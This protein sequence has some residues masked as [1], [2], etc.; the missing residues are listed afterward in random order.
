MRIIQKQ[1]ISGLQ[2]VVILMCILFSGLF[3]PGELRADP[4]KDQAQLQVLQSLNL[5][6]V[7]LTHIMTYNDKVVLDQEYNTIINN[8][9]LSNIPDADIITLLQELM[10]LLTSSKIRDHDREYIL[11]RF[12]K[13]IQNE[14]KNRIRSRI[15]DTD[16]VLNPYA[17][18][19]TA[20]L[21]TGS[22]YFNYRSQMDTY[23]KE[24]E[25]GKWAIEA[26]TM[27]G[28]NNF[29]K[30]LL[31]YSWD[32]M[33][34]YNLPDE[35]RL[36]E[37]QLSDYTDILKEPDLDRRYRKLERI[38]SSFQKFPPYWYYR[39]Q[40]A[41]EIGK[42]E[43]ALHCFNQFQQINQRILRK[44]P[45]AA[46]VAMCKTMLKAE[47]SDPRMLK[48]DLDLI[49]ANSEDADWGNILFVALQYER[50]GDSDTAGKLI[51]RNLDNGHIA[52][53]DT[54]DM[55]RTVGPALLLNARPDVFNRIM[56]MVVKNNKVNNYDLLWLYGKI[57]N[58]DILKKIQ[59]EFDRVLLQVADKSL[60]NPLNVFKGDNITL[61]LPTRWMTENALVTLRLK[62]EAGEKDFYPADASV[63]PDL[64]AMT[65]LTFKDVLPISSF[66]K[67]KSSAEI[68][69]SLI[70]EKLAA[71][72]SEKKAYDIEMVFKSQ[73]IR[74]DEQLAKTIKYTND[75]YQVG[76]PNLAGD[77]KKQDS[78]DL[79]IWFNK[80]KIIL[81]G[82]AFKWS[83]NGVTQAS[84]KAN[85][86]TPSPQPPP[87]VI[88]DDIPPPLPTDIPPPLPA[89][90]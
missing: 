80:E 5:I 83:D 24:K 90:Q 41:Q 21:R 62:N 79:T 87:P 3:I 39:G 37:K 56:D 16:L 70:R 50:L 55:I 7:S 82:E 73:I 74:S 44:D 30:K 51:L 47:E 27:E 4:N 40:A 14:L 29:Y 22:F 10:D 32:L 58:S 61:F 59:P 11:T 33:R 88:E 17:G 23:A 18:L 52:F 57:R 68:S 46:S 86:P 25:E 45:Y 35:W 69:I 76:T 43:E 48:K 67:K 1:F 84:K 12:D 77:K 72:N 71:D 20:V 78:D 2:S 13:N 34:R 60:L 36:N 89:P 53:I 9:N 49:L 81:N 38:E 31:K 42:N 85:P 19:L 65:V 28:L 54:P 75:L 63:M 66:I 8:L 15:F 6:A 26:K 64:P